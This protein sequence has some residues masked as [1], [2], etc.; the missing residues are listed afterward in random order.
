MQSKENNLEQRETTRK[1][2]I[3][4]ISDEN[5]TGKVDKGKKKSKKGTLQ[6]EKYQAKEYFF[7]RQ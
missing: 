4:E 3:D 2:E 5:E 7:I 6:M 1:T